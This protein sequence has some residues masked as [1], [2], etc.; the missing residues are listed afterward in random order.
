MTLSQHTALAI[1][2]AL[3]RTRQEVGSARHQISNAA[4]MECAGLRRRV[5]AIVE[6]LDA[7]ITEALE[8]AKVALLNDPNYDPGRGND[9]RHLAPWD[10]DDSDPNDSHA[11]ASRRPTR[12][13]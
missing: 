6:D 2:D 8:D 5:G 11:P 1:F 9:G 13:T 4:S 7:A 10:N 12:R 3:L